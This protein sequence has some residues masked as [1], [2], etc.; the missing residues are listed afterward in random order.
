MLGSI[1]NIFFM[2][3]HGKKIPTIFLHH[4]VQCLQ[5]ENMSRKTFRL[6]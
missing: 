1:E 2:W 5:N 4:P 6:Q 3:D